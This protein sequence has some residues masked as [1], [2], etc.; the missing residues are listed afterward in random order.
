MTSPVYSGVRDATFEQTIRNV[1]M[2]GRISE[3]YMD[4][5]MGEE[6]M[7]M[8][9]QVFT[10][11]SANKSR[12]YQYYETIGDV[13]INKIIVWYFTRRFPQLFCPEGVKIV[14]RLK[15][16]Y[17]SKTSFAPIAESLGFWDLISASHAERSA[18]K[19]P[20][21]EDTLE[22]FIGATEFFLDMKVRQGVGYAIVYD[23]ISNIFDE[24]EISLRYEDLFDSKTR[25]KEI[26]DYFKNGRP[27]V[28]PI[29]KE[30]YKHER[31]NDVFV[32]RLVRVT[33]SGVEDPL[34][35]GIAPILVD[36]QQK[37]ADK[38]LVRLKQ[39]GY[40]RPIPEDYQLF[41]PG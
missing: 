12:N 29:G 33:P 20:M 8:Y 30:L 22:A 36:A 38:G 6:A 39:L 26:F 21:L 17:G 41:S 15:I 1:L 27:G 10:H 25:V 31:E 23:I 4:V 40:V 14:S 3:R 16:N 7:R 19:R 34:G 18:K 28:A 2:R 24:K 37:A 5:L 9:D 35:A 11:D 13:T 32:V